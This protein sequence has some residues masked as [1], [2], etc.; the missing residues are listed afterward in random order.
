MNTSSAGWILLAFGLY[1]VLHS[2]L[3]ATRVKD[4]AAQRFGAAAV[5]RYY[6]LFF[7][8]VGVVSLLPVLALAAWLPTAC[9]T[10]C[11][12]GRCHSAC[13]ASWPAW[14]SWPPRCAK[15]ASLTSW[16]FANWPALLRRAAW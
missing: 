2:W 8:L 11:R 3:A 16:A 1:A 10:A 7:N 4:W 15:Q 12:S 6:R 5:Q 13:W 9:S 14:P